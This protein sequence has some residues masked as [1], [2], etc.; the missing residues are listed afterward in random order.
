LLPGF[1][2]ID[3]FEEAGGNV[4]FSILLAKVFVNHLR[5]MDLCNTRPI[6]GSFEL[7]QV[8]R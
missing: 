1:S 8:L 7:G 3:F 5:G 4:F 6:D 2:S